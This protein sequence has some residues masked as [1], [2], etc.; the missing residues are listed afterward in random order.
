MKKAEAAQ[1]I[2]EIC[3]D[4][5]SKSPCTATRNAQSEQ[6]KQRLADTSLHATPPMVV[7]AHPPHRW[8]FLPYM[9]TQH[10]TLLQ[11]PHKSM[12]STRNQQAEQ[13]QTPFLSIRP[14]QCIQKVRLLKKVIL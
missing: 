14:K 4:Y 3:W 8:L 9:V 12:K 13:E 2:P 11:M 1:L 7:P 6:Q 10:Y 5:I